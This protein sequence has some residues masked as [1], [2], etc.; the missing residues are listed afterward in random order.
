MVLINHPCF[1]LK[2]N[3]LLYALET[4]HIDTLGF[5]GSHFG[6]GVPDDSANLI[7]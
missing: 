2:I 7:K 5:V 4:Y 6:K 1:S 3:S